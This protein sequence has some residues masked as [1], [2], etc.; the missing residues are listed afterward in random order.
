MRNSRLERILSN[1][2][3]SKSIISLVVAGAIT[4][5]LRMRHI[6]DVDTSILF[7]M[8]SV[9][10]WT[11]ATITE[12]IAHHLRHPRDRLRDDA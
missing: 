12:K 8:L 10:V 4:V 2:D 9:V 1:F 5:V 7:L 11:V 6:V 3:N